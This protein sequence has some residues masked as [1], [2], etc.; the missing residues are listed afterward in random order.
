[1]IDEVAAK[2]AERNNSSEHVR[3]QRVLDFYGVLTGRQMTLADA[4]GPSASGASRRASVARRT[5]P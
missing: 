2:R 3:K 1:M 4:P 5:V